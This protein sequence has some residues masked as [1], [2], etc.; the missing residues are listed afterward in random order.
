M[1]DKWG[2]SGSEKPN[3]KNWIS[4][5][6]K[7]LSFCLMGRNK[8][9]SFWSTYLISYSITNPN[10]SPLPSTIPPPPDLLLNSSPLCSLFISWTHL[11]SSFSSSEL[12]FSLLHLWTHLTPSFSYATTSAT[13]KS[14]SRSPPSL[15][16]L[17]E[18]LFLLLLN[19]KL[20][21]ESLPYIWIF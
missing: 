21:L 4:E 1:R 5:V 11:A 12:L 16:S 18:T 8:T 20:R 2:F 15:V 13:V 17:R 19:L 7:M 3:R 10:F 9:M 6:I 14:E